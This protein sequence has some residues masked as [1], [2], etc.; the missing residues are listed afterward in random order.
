MA[1]SSTLFSVLTFS[2]VQGTGARVATAVTLSVP[3]PNRRSGALP[4]LIV[5]GAQ[6]C[7]TSALHYYVGLHPEAQVSS[8]KELSFFLDE[9]D[10]HPEP[11][12]SVPEE[13][14]LVS[15]PRNWK[16][17]REWYESHFD[18]GA[19]IRG[20]ATPAYAS[21]W[22]PGTAERMAGLVGEAKLIFMVRDPVER[23]VSHYLQNRASGREWRPLDRALERR[24]NVYV[25]RSSYASVLRPFTERFPMERILVLRQ[26]DLLRDRR[27]TL[28][29]VFGF[30]GIDPEFWTPR[31]ERERHP[32]AR[33]GWR[34]RALTRVQS[35]RLARPIYRLPQEAKWLIERM[36]YRP[37]PA[38]RPAPD[39]AMRARILEQLEPEIAELE[40]ITGWD[41]SDWRDG[42][43]AP[44]S[45]TPPRSRPA[46]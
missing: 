15:G 23:M 45:R 26:E 5:I 46:R 20:E 35:S 27:P 11:Y 13:L 14:R 7:G 42:P 6:K 8:P 4:N 30:L 31:F 40:R 2:S 34:Y 16:R 36:S 44:R 3:P 1:D 33:K 38:E 9:S 12:L 32:T 22:F 19:A 10:F 21:P 24:Q 17:G 41:L 39:A 43:A 28:R 29:R 18:P 25:A 37:A